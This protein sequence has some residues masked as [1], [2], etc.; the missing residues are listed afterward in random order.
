M[1]TTTDIYQ[2]LTTSV[3]QTTAA[4]VSTLGVLI[5]AYL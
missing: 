3:I 2:P 4:I 1:N 5:V